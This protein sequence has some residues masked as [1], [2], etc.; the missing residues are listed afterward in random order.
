MLSS[1]V[2]AQ[3]K[4]VIVF[5]LTLLVLFSGSCA[6]SSATSPASECTYTCL[7][8]CLCNYKDLILDLI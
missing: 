8:L 6:A 2:M 7:M 5:A 4:N 1:I 3:V